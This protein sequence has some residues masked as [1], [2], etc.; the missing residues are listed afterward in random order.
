MTDLHQGVADLSP[1]ERELFELLLRKQ[2]LGP[3]GGDSPPLSF[4]QQRFWLLEQLERDNPSYN[5]PLAIRL[6]GVLD[7]AALGRSFTEIIRRHEV[8]RTACRTVNGQPVL[9]PTPPGEVGLP[10][11]DLRELPAGQRED[12][13]QRLANREARRPF[14][15]A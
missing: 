8:L 15:L 4:A 14:D 7:V 6:E 11:V 12:E 3:P 2:G 13:A 10:V 5:I 1:E 9:V